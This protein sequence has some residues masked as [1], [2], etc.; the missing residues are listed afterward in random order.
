MKTHR[1]VNTLSI[2]ENECHRKNQV[3]LWFTIKYIYQENLTKKF[4]E[5]SWWAL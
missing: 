4:N 3:F 5:V 1:V 2:C